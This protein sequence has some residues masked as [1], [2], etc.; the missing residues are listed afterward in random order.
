MHHD[1]STTTG[2][3]EASF[4]D[5]VERLVMIRGHRRY[6]RPEIRRC[7]TCGTYYEFENVYEWTTL[8]NDDDDYARR[9]T[10]SEALPLLP[11]AERAELTARWPR[12]IADL[13]RCL[14]SSRAAIAGYAARSVSGDAA[15]A[16]TS[17]VTAPMAH[18][19]TSYVRRSEETADE[20]D[21]KCTACG[22]LLAR[23]S[24][25]LPHHSYLGEE[26]MKCPG[27]QGLFVHDTWKHSLVQVTAARLEQVLRSKDQEALRAHAKLRCPRCSSSRVTTDF[28]FEY[29][30]RVHCDDCGLQGGDDLGGYF[31]P[32]TGNWDETII[33]TSETQKV[34]QEI[35]RLCPP[36]TPAQDACR[37]LEGQGFTCQR[38]AGQGDRIECS[39]DRWD[40]L[41]T[42]S[43][44]V[45]L[46]LDPK[47]RLLDCDVEF[48]IS[49]E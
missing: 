16:G 35:V 12:L 33:L 5:G 1:M 6:D 3:T 45:V 44:T 42:R 49:R 18:D 7:P 34:R 47:A 26:L 43:W 11:E 4:P 28:E 22:G 13:T 20:P 17:E 14:R 46:H 8:G 48:Q 36:R 19:A 27:C 15:G 10:P 37:L 31:D 23:T 41:E 39:Y 9:L 24:S 25:R 21:L 2:A 38:V 32:E 40:W 29:S 30:W